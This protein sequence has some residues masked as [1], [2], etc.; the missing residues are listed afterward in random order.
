MSWRRF[1][2]SLAGAPIRPNCSIHAGG[3]F[4][5]AHLFGLK[6]TSFVLWRPAN[7]TVPPRLVIGDFTPGN[8]PSLGNQR[9]F[10]LRLL[11][12]Q[13]DLW[14]IDVSACS[15]VEGTVYHYWF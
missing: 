4:M 2:C 11:P 8:P 12:G 14:G 7:T 15:L 13:T 9:E 10:D 3:N 6:Q 5:T 1:R